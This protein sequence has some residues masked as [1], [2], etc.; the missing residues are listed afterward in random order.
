[1]KALEA[2]F[3]DG[4]EDAGAELGAVCLF[5]GGAET[6]CHFCGVVRFSSEVRGAGVCS[7]WW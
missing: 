1:M 5:G 4:L 6:F 2:G 7:W 3:L